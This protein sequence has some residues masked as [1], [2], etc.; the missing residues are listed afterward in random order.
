MVS[1]EL[2]ERSRNAI[3]VDISGQASVPMT[4]S[5]VKES[6]LMVKVMNS[7]ST[8]DRVVIFG[9]ESQT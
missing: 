5:A 4:S 2:L 9:T 6:E 3:V 8:K 7:S 1:E